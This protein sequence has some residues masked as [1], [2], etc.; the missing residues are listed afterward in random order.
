MKV[1]V[2]VIGLSI[3]SA[4]VAVPIH[5]P[6]QPEKA[7]PEA[8]FAVSVTVVDEG[9]LYVQVDPQLIP[10]GMLATVPPPLLITVRA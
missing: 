7:Y 2:T 9:K 4:H 6:L 10:E 8:A 1:A 5:A 3:V